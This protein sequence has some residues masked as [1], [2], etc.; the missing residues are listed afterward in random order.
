MSSDSGSEEEEEEQ[1]L[2]V[3]QMREKRARG[4]SQKKRKASASSSGNGSKKVKKTASNKAKKKAPTLPVRRGSAKSSEA[5]SDSEESKAEEA[6]TQKAKKQKQKP[7]PMNFQPQEDIYLCKAVVNISQD[8]AKG[9]DQK[10]GVYWDRIKGKFDDLVAKDSDLKDCPDRN[11]A[12]LQSRFD[13]NIKKQ[14]NLFNN[15]YKRHKDSNPS[16]WNEEKFIDESCESFLKGEGK[17]FAWV[18][19]AQILWKCPKF[20]P[21]LTDLTMDPDD[22][23]AKTNRVTKVMGQDMERPLGSKKTKAGSTTKKLDAA[24]IATMESTKNEY[25]RGMM[26]A[27]FLMSDTMEFQTTMNR[28]MDKA[29]LYQQMGR[30][31]DCD[32]VLADIEEQEKLRKEYFKKKAQPPSVI[33]IEEDKTGVST[34]ESTEEVVGE[35]DHIAQNTAKPGITMRSAVPNDDDEEEDDEDD[36]DEVDITKVAAHPV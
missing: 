36:D 19:C 34:T 28:M 23:D 9:T 35:S 16:G 15:Y 1:A 27:S 3:K 17:P 30:I 25:I 12:S 2:T 6:P 21:L 26:N 32:Q 7:R 14:V 4:R 29:R 11:S 31:D 33:D 10:V 20:D 22:E 8:A 24:T 13:R 18:Q 5:A